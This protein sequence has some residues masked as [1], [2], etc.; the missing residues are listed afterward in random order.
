M[1]LTSLFVAVL[2]V[3]A[4]TGLRAASDRPAISG[5]YV[6]VRTAEVFTGPCML[7]N[8]ADSLGREA[9]LAWRVSSGA[10][11]GVNLDG[12]SVVAVVA[13]D[14]NL[15]MHEL[16][17]R[18]PSVVKALMMVDERAN[19]AQR[20]ALVAMAQSL[21]PNLVRDVVETKAVAIAFSRDS[22]DVRVNAG[23]ANLDVTTK[24]EHSPVCGA[25]QW[26]NPL[27]STTNSELAVARSHAFSGKVLGTQWK[28]ADKK[29]S[30]VGTFRYV[31]E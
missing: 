1:K 16:G 5:D 20:A 30:Y 12:L 22:A 24:F 31:A 3:A 2:A 26:F 13:G 7:G 18:R 14:K 25:M 29:S 27:A 6:E 23:E 17:D 15:G 10:V 4:G 11:N 19:P 21:S 8:E 9:I 28:Q